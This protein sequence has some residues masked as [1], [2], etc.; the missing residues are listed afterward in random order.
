MNYKIRKLKSIIGYEKKLLSIIQKELSFTENQEDIY[1]KDKV[2]K[3][4]IL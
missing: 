4:E 3:Q 1:K 2:I